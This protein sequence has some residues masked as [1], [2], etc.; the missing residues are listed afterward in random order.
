MALNIGKTVTDALLQANKTVELL[1]DAELL[2]R[3]TSLPPT[4]S[5]PPP[6]TWIPH[7]CKAS[8]ALAADRREDEGIVKGDQV[9]WL[10]GLTLPEGIRP[11]PLWRIT[12]AD[13]TYEILPDVQVA[14]KD[15]A[16]WRCNCKVYWPEPDSGDI[17]VQWNVSQPTNSSFALGDIPR[18]LA[19]NVSQPSDSSFTLN[20]NV[21]ELAWS[22]SQPSDSSFTL[23]QGGVTLEWSVSQPSD[24]GFKLADI[25]HELAWNVSQSSDSSF[26]LAPIPQE[27]KWGVTQ[28]S[29]S[30]FTL[31]PTTAAFILDNDN[32]PYLDNDDNPWEE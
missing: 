1:V 24:S 19:F 9:I 18:E 15:K 17:P 12:I 6:I 7:K 11:Y 29:D 22:V 26:A 5:Q 16:A 8:I 20:T 27:L 13:T 23:N 28:P 4:P 25:T 30:S 2:E 10:L 32:N 14:G 31:N 3:K 21:R